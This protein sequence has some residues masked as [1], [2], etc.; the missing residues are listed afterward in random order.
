M[1]FITFC[2]CMYYTRISLQCNILLL[3]KIIFFLCR[4]RV[5]W[6]EV[7]YAGLKCSIIVR[8]GFNDRSLVM[9]KPEVNFNF[10]NF[11]NLEIE[12]NQKFFFFSNRFR[13][14]FCFRFESSFIYC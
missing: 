5:E 8:D 10:E 3:R 12:S 14:E 6:N 2:V 13:A 1:R 7:D 4:D 11:K 9:I